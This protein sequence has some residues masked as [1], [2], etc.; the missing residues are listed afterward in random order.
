MALVLADNRGSRLTSPPATPFSF[1]TTTARVASRR[2]ELAE[3]P[4]STP[5]DR[6]TTA[7]ELD[8]MVLGLSVG[9]PVA[10]QGERSDLP[11]VEAAE[12]AAL[13]DVIHAGGRTTL[14]LEAGLEHAYVRD[15]LTISANVVHANH[16][17]TTHELLG[18]GDASVPNQHFTL[19]KPPLTYVSAPTPRGS[20]STLEVRVNGVRW[21]EA[22]SLYGLDPRREAHVVRIDDEGRAHVVFGD[23]EQGARLP[24]GAANVSATYRSGIGRD[25]EVEA[26]SLT[27]FRTMPLGVRSVTN[28]VA[29]AGAEGPERLEDARRNAPLTVL[30]FERVVSPTDYEDF[31]RTFPGIGKAL[32]DRLW[33]DD[34]VL[35]HLTVAGAT[36]KA[37][38]P[39]V[40]RNLVEAIQRAND[41]SQSFSASPFAQRYFTCEARLAVDPRYVAADVLSAVEER[42]RAAFGF[43]SRQL[44]QSVT[45]AEVVALVHSVAGVIAVDLESLAPYEEDASGTA[46]ASPGADGVPARRAPVGILLVEMK[47]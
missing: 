11:G 31:A 18:S 14:V 24:S 8:R 38:S 28:P 32:A 21:E 3:L 41:R 42:L 20:R 10:F 37:P 6:G 12:I 2:L 36:G 7:L 33:V 1:R 26:G 40:L 47:P 45:A 4:I 29:A 23:G 27:V 13:A 5:V 44:G 46:G 16:G 30:T 43:E 22:S 25:G 19:K 9:Q 34:R 35:M 39:D 17:E 15:K